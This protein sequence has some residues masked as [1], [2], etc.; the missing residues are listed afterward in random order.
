MGTKPR[1]IAIIGL[2]TFGLSVARQSALLGDRVLGIDTKEVHVGQ[3]CD[4]IDETIQADGTDLKALES[5]GLDAYDSIVVS[6]GANV[7]SSIL[8]AM[9]VL[10]LG[11]QEIWV[12]AQHATHEK[13][14]R[15][16]GIKN[17]VL[18]ELAYGLHLAQLLHNPLMQDY[19]SLGDDEYVTKIA[20][21][22]EAVGQPIKSLF[23][24]QGEIRCIGVYRQ[25]T[26][27]SENFF[28]LFFEA[29]DMVL[30][31]GNQAALESYTNK[32]ML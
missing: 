23:N 7:E 25:G 8:V 19:V 29:H 27:F 26:L 32:L 6:I 17:V 30:L 13:I 20:I 5:I 31:F 24:D 15:A 2:G 11:C 16:I 28:D 12:K 22:E 4:E 1:S 10:E 9:N 3:I 14:L 18:P 21:T